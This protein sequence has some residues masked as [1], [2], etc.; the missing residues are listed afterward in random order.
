[1]ERVSTSG[2]KPQEE[3][4]PAIPKR[5]VFLSRK[6]T[7]PIF[8]NDMGDAWLQLLNMVM[9]IG[10]EKR[11]AD[12]DRL[13]EALNA[14]VTIELA[15]EDEFPE[16][17]TFD[18]DDFDRHYRRFEAPSASEEARGDYGERL[19]DW[20]GVDQIDA[21]CGRLQE[22]PDT[23]S[24]TIVCL[25]PGDMANPEAAPGLISA[26][27]NTVEGKLF[28]SFVLR[29]VDIFAAWALEAMALV[30]L[31]RDVAQRIGLEIGSATFVVHSAY[32]Y[33]RDWARSLQVL[34]EH[35]KRPLPLQVDPSGIFLFGNDGGKARAMLLDHDASTIYW[36]DAFDNPED[37]SWYIIDTMPW[38]LPQHMRYVG[39]ECA[40][41]MRAIREGQ[42]YLQ[43]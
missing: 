24:A 41:L 38:L 26:T 28:G 33:A 9:K 23:P 10:V 29:A 27:F 12:G 16:F 35:F 36:E 14:V 8:G 25:Q 1:M 42:C 20:D 43:G 15:A 34:D 31:Q 40:S 6:T 13:A 37:L 7:Y 18:R 19:R 30:R 11:G 3:A 32:L 39:Q 2:H 4:A 5:K 22:S 21:V 17:L